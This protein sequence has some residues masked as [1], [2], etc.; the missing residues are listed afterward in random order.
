VPQLSARPL[1]GRTIMNKS[2][3]NILILLF[4]LVSKSSSQIGVRQKNIIIDTVDKSISIE[5]SKRFGFIFV[6]K[7]QRDYDSLNTFTNIYSKKYADIDT[8]IT[9]H[10]TDTQLDSIYA[11]IREIHFLNYPKDYK[12]KEIFVG[13]QPHFSYYLKVCVDKYENELS[14]DADIMSK[15]SSTKNLS[16][17]F[18]LIKRMIKS[19]PDYQKIRKP[20]YSPLY[21]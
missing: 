7:I 15:D 12:S 6:Y 13:V 14:I 5:R 17:L 4:L 16:N 18:S 9:F 1:G 20:S 21:R 11:K 19:S 3:I 2:V 8:S 10:L